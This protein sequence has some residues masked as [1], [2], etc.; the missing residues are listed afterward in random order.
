MSRHG[1]GELLGVQIIG[2]V[3]KHV[4]EDQGNLATSHATML[5]KSKAHKLMY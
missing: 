5:E 4:L 2:H 1:P 3:L